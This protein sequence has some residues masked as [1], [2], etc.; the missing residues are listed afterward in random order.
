M[1]SGKGNKRK[2]KT[3]TNDTRNTST[4]SVQD[5]KDD[6]KETSIDHVQD[7]KDDTKETSIDHVRSENDDNKEDE[8]VNDPDKPICPS[9]TNGAY[10]QHFDP[11]PAENKSNNMKT[12]DISK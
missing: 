3:A 6:T 1:T 5:A 8:K 2:Q 4:D 12:I 10:S 11:I 7:A 9:A